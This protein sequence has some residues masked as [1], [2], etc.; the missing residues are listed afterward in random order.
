MCEVVVK[1]SSMKQIRMLAQYLCR[2]D[3]EKWVWCAFHALALALVVLAIVVQMAVTG[4]A[5]SG[6]EKYRRYSFHLL[7]C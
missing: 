1:E 7:A 2:P 6:V 5:W 3:D 4:R